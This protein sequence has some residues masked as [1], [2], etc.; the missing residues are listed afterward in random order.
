MALAFGHAMSHNMSNA[1][2]GKPRIQLNAS[3]LAQFVDA[4]PR[5]ETAQQVGHR[6]SPDDPAVRLP[7]YRRL[8]RRDGRT[9]YATTRA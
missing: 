8:R 6:P 4:L 7:Y 1:D 3:S 5:L 9:L 2:S